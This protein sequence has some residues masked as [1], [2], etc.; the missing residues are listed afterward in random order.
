MKKYS[1]WGLMVLCT[2]FW[3]GNYIFGKYVTA[4]LS[5]V[6]ISLIRWAI[7]SCLLVPIAY[8]TEKPSR[9]A[10]RSHLLP[11]AAMGV[12]G[13]VMYTYFVYAALRFTSSTNAALVN[14]ITPATIVLFARIFL[15]E[16]ATGIQVT[17]ILVSLLG[18]LIVLTGG[19][20]IA[21]FSAHYNQGDLI[22]LFAV[23]VWSAYSIIGKH[24]HQVPPITMTAVSAVI[25]TL[26]LLPFAL[27]EGADFSQVNTLALIGMAYIS[28]FP[29]VLAFIFWNIGVKVIGPS[30]AG[31]FLNLMPVFTAIISWA[32][33]NKITAAQIGGGLL[34]ILGVTFTTGLIGRKTQLQK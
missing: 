16:K 21:A 13:I 7:A 24:M 20:P 27:I 23:I 19:N 6:W 22:M 10:I 33:G 14:S 8:F 9:E 1:V 28:F 3:A 11:L 29:S 26:I 17:G 15:K 12:L 32:L 30:R 34:V 4:T 31:I 25:G 18:V 5:P 2:A